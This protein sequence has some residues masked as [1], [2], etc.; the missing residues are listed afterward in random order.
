MITVFP[1][2]YK[3]NAITRFPLAIYMEPGADN[4]S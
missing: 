3:D 2:I 1:E 4:L